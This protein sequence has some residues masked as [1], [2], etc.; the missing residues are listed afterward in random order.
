MFPDVVVC[1]SLGAT[2]IRNLH[3]TPYMSEHGHKRERGLITK[4]AVDLSK[5][6]RWHFTDSM[7]GIEETEEE[8][9]TVIIALERTI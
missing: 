6:W 1:M 2:D 4:S 8:W 5:K 9:T 7:H 3:L